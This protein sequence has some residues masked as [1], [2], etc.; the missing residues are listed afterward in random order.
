[1]GEPSCL[2]RFGMMIALVTL[3]VLAGLRVV[4]QP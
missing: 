4:R 1:M 3:A 2:H